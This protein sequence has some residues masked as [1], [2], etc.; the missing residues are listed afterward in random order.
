M[1][2]SSFSYLLF[3]NILFVYEWSLVNAGRD[4]QD[5]NDIVHHPNLGPL[6]PRP[7]EKGS[8]VPSNWQW[9]PVLVDD[10]SSNN[11][12]TQNR[13]NRIFQK[14]IMYSSLSDEENRIRN[15]YEAKEQQHIRDKQNQYNEN[16]KKQWRKDRMN[17]LPSKCIISRR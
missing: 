15:E 1:L 17:S 12:H 3:L 4:H 16:M 11:S 13:A 14:N 8:Q 7:G 10:L 5:R 9:R 6:P 2:F